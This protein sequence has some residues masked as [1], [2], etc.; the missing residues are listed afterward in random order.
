MRVPAGVSQ[1]PSTTRLAIVLL[2]S[3]PLLDAMV[4]LVDAGRAAEPVADDGCLL[5]VALTL[6]SRAADLHVM[7][8][9]CQVVK[10]LARRRAN[11]EANETREGLLLCTAVFVSAL[12][13][14]GTEPDTVISVC[15]AMANLAASPSFQAALAHAGAVPRLASLMDAHPTNPD[16]LEAA[17]ATLLNLVDL[18][19]NHVAAVWAGVPARMS[20][21]LSLHA[22]LPALAEAATGVLLNLADSAEEER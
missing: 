12:A 10:C 8:R 2:R 3:P 1:T 4:S 5:A 6:Q 20:A 18:Q 21:A 7:P 9:A 13:V 19:A 17:S 22:A 11:V 16:V 14:H 15:D